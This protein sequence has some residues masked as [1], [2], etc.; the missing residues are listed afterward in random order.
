MSLAAYVAVFVVLTRRWWVAAATSVPTGNHPSDSR[1][2]VW[3]L[4]W[5]YRALTSEP[6]RLFDAPIYFP[7]PAQ[8]TG[9]EH[10]LSSQIAFAP[11][12]ALTGNAVLATNA[13][14]LASYP[15]AAF[16]ME[17]LLAALGIGRWAAWSAGLLFALGPLRVPASFQVPQ[18]LHLYLPVVAL[19]L[20]RLRDAPT[21]PRVLV[22]ALCL[23]LGVFSAYYTAAMVVAVVAVWGVVEVARPGRRAGF[24]GL[25]A[26][27]TLGVLLLLAAFS[28]PYFR[29]A[30][31]APL[32]RDALALPQPSPKPRPSAM[33]GAT[34]VPHAVPWDAALPLV[35]PPD[36]RVAP[37]AGTV[38]LL[39][40]G[41]RGLRRIAAAGLAFVA[42]GAG[43]LV[44]LVAAGGMSPAVAA[45][46]GFFRH[47]QRTQMLTGFGLSLLAAGALATCGRVAGRRAE[48]AAALAVACAVLWTRGPALVTPKLDRVALE[49]GEAAAYDEIGRIAARGGDGSLLELPATGRDGTDLRPRSLLGSLRHR[50]PLANGFS[51]HFPS[52]FMF[53]NVRI[54]RLPD[55]SSLQD[56]VDV[57]HVRW[58]VL[59]P[60]ED[61]RAPGERERVRAGLL[62]VAGTS[63][64]E[65]GR[66]T[67]IDVE[68]PRERPEL[69]QAI[70]SGRA[71]AQLAPA[72]RA[73]LA[74]WLARDPAGAS[75]GGR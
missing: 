3:I 15:I 7:A 60:E 9:S 73:V 37:I 4:G 48:V 1:L 64:T 27:A 49:D 75:P 17:R 58:I 14:V 51:G 55:E 59:R 33:P 52:H 45:I 38:G 44:W 54:S 31:D 50:V 35:W 36:D 72:E 42:L 63:A 22:Y 20:H 66:F 53:L 62:S 41:V 2:H 40:L 68:R 28:L 46:V 18:L 56:L 69:F 65:V 74:P 34:A 5:V 13:L 26:V 67:V 29:R 71:L 47:V 11:V 32:P 16:A 10:F 25:A 24:A 30:P 39:A 23:A 43:S 70:A 6:S 57:A 12:Y 19:A 8:L 61:W 21:A